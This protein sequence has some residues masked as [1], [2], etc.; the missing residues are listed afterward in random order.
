MPTFKSEGLVIKREDFAEYNRIYT[1]YTREYGKISCVAEG[2]RKIK[3]KQAGHLE[4]FTHVQCMFAL[5]RSHRNKLATAV[6]VNAFSKIRQ[7]F[8][9]IALAH[10]CLELV[11]SAVMEEEKDE[12]IFD[13]LI[14]IFSF[15]DMNTQR[16]VHEA[17]LSVRVFGFKLLSHLGYKPELLSCLGCQGI[18]TDDHVV[19]HTLR[20]GLFEERCLDEKFDPYMLRINREMIISLSLLLE[21]GIDHLSALYFETNTIIQLNQILKKYLEI[22][23]ERSMKTDFWLETMFQSKNTFDDRPL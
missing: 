14:E 7:D 8:L 18:I 10:Y 1:I 5:G 11:D 9:V 6:T 2:V 21:Q 13:L 17:V 16:S 20:G 3:S 22:H 15:L 19:F 4:P 12:F 23:L